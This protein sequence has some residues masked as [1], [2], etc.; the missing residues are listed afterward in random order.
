MLPVVWQAV[1]L[2]I[3][4]EWYSRPGLFDGTRPYILQVFSATLEM[5]RSTSIG[6]SQSGHLV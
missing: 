4:F 1:L 6:T 3:L 5:S 2:S